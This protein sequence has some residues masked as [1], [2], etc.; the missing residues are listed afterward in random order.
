M[1]HLCGANCEHRARLD[2]AVAE[3]EASSALLMKSVFSG[4][5]DAIEF[6]W[7]PLRVAKVRLSSARATFRENCQLYQME[8]KRFA[9]EYR[10]YKV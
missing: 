2:A 8:S 9:Q 7:S 5:D 6:A 10:E 3:L 1:A 4:S